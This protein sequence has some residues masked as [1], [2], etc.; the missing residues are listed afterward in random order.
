M[1]ETPQVRGDTSPP[2]EE[3]ERAAHDDKA[4]AGES[5]EIGFGRG[6]TSADALPDI[7]GL[8][9]DAPPFWR[10]IA[11]E[12]WGE[13]R[14]GLVMGGIVLALGIALTAFQLYVALTSDLD[15]RQQR[16]LHLML[17]MLM[18][19]AVMPPFKRARFGGSPLAFVP[20][21]VLD[22]VM[23]VATVVV[24]LYPIVFQTELARRAG[25]YT[26]LDWIMGA[27]AIVVLLEATRRAVGLV[28]VVLVSGFLYY[29]W[30]GPL[31]PGQFGHSGATIQRIS[32]HSYLGNDGIYG[33]TLGVVVTFVFVF[34]LFGA[35]LTKTGGGNFFIGL[36]YVLTGRMVGGPAK[37]AVLGSALMGS[38][39][40]SAIANVVTT[41]PFTIPLMKK[42]G[43]KK[44]DAAGVE[45]AA[46][47]G[48]QVLPPIM[49][50]GAFLM[51]ERL[52]IPYADIVKVAIIPALMYFGLMFLFVDILARKNNIRPMT[53]DEIP[54]FAI[55]MRAGWHFLAPLILL[56]VLLLNYVPPTQAGLAACGALLV[57][58]M[59]RAGSRLSLK[60][61]LEVFVMAARSTLPV[62]V[63]CAVAGI[64]VGMVGLTGLGL[65]F[66][67]V[68]VNAFAGNLFMTLLMVALASLILGIGLP[69]TAAYVVLVILA[70][71]ALEQLGLA[72][73][74]A[75]MIV[76]W[77]SQDSNVTP[78]VAFATFAAAGIADSKPMRSGV[79]S[80]KF[81]KGLYL[82]PLLMAYSSLMEV[83]GPLLDLVIAIATGSVALAAGA[84]A[85]EGYFLRRTLLGERIALGVAAALVIIAPE[86]TGWTQA[87]LSVHVAPDWFVLAGTALGVV[88]IALQVVNHRRDRARGR[89]APVGEEQPQAAHG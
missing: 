83:D 50:A 39:S 31:I 65:V 70:G 37:G 26:D 48:G 11:A 9:A 14:V 23:V 1:A 10:R 82:I 43:Y 78:P 5:P 75:H 71:P 73:I 58:A 61:F 81:A 21:V 55:V 49:G 33:L 6:G 25:A 2:P 19:F 29:A 66:S 35:L 4:G 79:S 89:V 85:I 28:M 68:L 32:T 17:V 24:S 54:V 59:L 76:Y 3:P 13:G 56:I 88:L 80:W 40:G 60:D 52:G 22:L 62:T 20:G 47:T 77:L 86:W 64:I 45:S 42:V 46:S 12:R 27:V 67:D 69:V 8:G 53:K 16:L 7:D 74:V 57:V 63:A 18:V 87:L 44:H 36:A 72:L 38:V 51:A 34:I 84:M 30:I 15:A 41:G